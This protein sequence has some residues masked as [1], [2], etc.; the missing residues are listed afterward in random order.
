MNL[1]IKSGS[2]VKWLKIIA[3]RDSSLGWVDFTREQQGSMTIEFSAI[4]L[5][6]FLLYIGS[7][8]LF[9]AFDINRKLNLMTTGVAELVGT[10]ETTKRKDVVDIMS[11]PDLALEPY[12][13][14]KPTI[15]ITALK[16]TMDS[17]TSATVLWSLQ[18]DN[19]GTVTALPVGQVIDLPTDIG[20]TG[21]HL[22]HVE[23][24]LVYLPAF[25]WPFEQSFTMRKDY[26]ILPRYG[27]QA[28]ACNDCNK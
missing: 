4:V 23:S 13:K 8:E 14:A 18:A 26:Y 12:K 20:G 1:S 24:K 15:T 2:I 3:P 17:P 11:L 27:S 10:L 7:A 21:S 19:A 28:I 6:F 16:T 22:I 25:L 5:V 9:L